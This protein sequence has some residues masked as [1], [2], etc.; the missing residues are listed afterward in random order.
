MLVAARIK[1]V[2]QDK[3]NSARA[4]G[5]FSKKIN[6]GTVIHLRHKGDG[7][8][9]YPEQFR[10]HQPQMCIDI[11]ETSG[12]PSNPK[13]VTV[14][15]GVNGEKLRP[16]YVNRPLKGLVDVSFCVPYQCLSF[17][18]DGYTKDVQINAWSVRV[19]GDEIY[20]DHEV[21][22]SGPVSEVTEPDYLAPLKAALDKADSP[23]RGFFYYDNSLETKV[24]SQATA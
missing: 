6:Q 16:Y 21:L 17:E 10:G 12:D 23:T 18:V 1:G 9:A 22:F 24:N 5:L 2:F 4:E 15:S 8:Y 3:I 19:R 7:Y 13:K 11:G 20:L 14:I